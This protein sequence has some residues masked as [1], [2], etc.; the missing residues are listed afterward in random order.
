MPK[1]F[2]C[3][4]FGHDWKL[5]GTQFG[6]DEDTRTHE[7]QRCGKTISEK[8]GENMERPAWREIWK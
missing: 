2:W 5:T 8:R 6:H 7:C 1:V 3:C 4:V